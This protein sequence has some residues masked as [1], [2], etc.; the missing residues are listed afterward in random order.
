MSWS[1]AILG[2]FLASAAIYGCTAAALWPMM[3]RAFLGW[4]VL[5]MFAI[6]AM[7]LALAPAIPATKWLSGADFALIGAVSADLALACCGPLLASYVEPHIAADRER[8]RLRTM[9]PLAL[10]P[11]ALL[12]TVIYAGKF[13]WLHDVLMLTLLMLLATN[14]GALVRKGSRAAAFQSIAWAPALVLV[15]LAIGH[16]VFAGGMMPLYVEALLVALIFELVVSAVGIVDGFL[17]IMRERDRAVADMHLARIATATDPLTDIANRRGLD[18][19]FNQAGPLR[20]SGLAL[21]DCDHFKRI[22]DQFGHDTGDR[23]LVAVAQ[24]LQG[25]NLFEARLGGEEFVVLIYGSDWQRLAESARRRITQTVRN[26]VP[27]LPFAVTASAGLAPVEPGD[28][29]AEAMKRADR[30]LYA[31]KEAGR[32]RSLML[33]ELHPQGDGLTEVA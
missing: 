11:I 19:H 28:T 17:G 4:A 27:E 3:R 29:L 14:L 13:D 32:N 30:A 12:P 31:A 24:A 15:T 7:I 5:R 25:E 16:E 20:P 6:T 10:V 22:N 9:L 2:A 21:I 23:V 18:Q 8:S 33:T 1:S 26:H